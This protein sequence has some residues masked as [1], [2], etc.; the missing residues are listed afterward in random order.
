[1]FRLRYWARD[2]F[3]LVV[4]I[5]PVCFFTR[6]F[7]R[8][9]IEEDSSKPLMSQRRDPPCFRDLPRT[10]DSSIL[11]FC[12]ILKCCL[13]PGWNF[14]PFYSFFFFPLNSFLFHLK[15]I[16]SLCLFNGGGK[17]P[18][19]GDEGRPSKLCSPGNIQKARTDWQM[20]AFKYLRNICFQWF[21]VF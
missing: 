20:H 18:K 10:E 9:K 7:W 16:I 21:R 1:M 19:Q 4:Q 8:Y 13:Y 11:K 15:S 5:S 14:Y 2:T 17:K 12:W 3:Y 6:W